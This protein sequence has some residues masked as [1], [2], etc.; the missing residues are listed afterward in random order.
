METEATSGASLAKVTV[1]LET[2][3]PNASR[4]STVSGCTPPRW[5]TALVGVTSIVV[6]TWSTTIGTSAS[7][8][9]GA[10]TTMVAVPFCRAVTTPKPSTTAT[11]LLVVR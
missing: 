11:V 5:R 9:S 3:G 6:G 4:T 7:S 8:R 10:E 1:G 2:G